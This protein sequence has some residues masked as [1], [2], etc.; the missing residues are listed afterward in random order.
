MNSQLRKSFGVV[1]LAFLGTC[2]GCLG[3]NESNSQTM[4][5]PPDKDAAPEEGT[6]GNPEKKAS[7]PV[8][9]NSIFSNLEISLTAD[10]K[11]AVTWWF[12]LDRNTK[13]SMLVEVDSKS[14]SSLK[15]LDE[16]DLNSITERVTDAVTKRVV[17][18]AKDTKLRRINTIDG[19]R[20]EAHEDR[21]AAHDNY[22]HALKAEGGNPEDSYSD[23]DLDY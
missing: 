5:T 17:G 22:R 19:E 14:A 15:S 4:N 12:T 8:S 20:H 11:S 9:A 3:N 7:T 1:A 13:N 21:Q 6:Q 18:K 10:E 16:G 2:Y 23:T